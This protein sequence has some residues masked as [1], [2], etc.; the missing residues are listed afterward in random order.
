MEEFKA[1]PVFDKA[2][3]QA[4]GWIKD[5]MYE[6]NLEDSAKTYQ[7]LRVTLHTLRDRILPHEAVHLGAQLP[8]LLRGSYYDGWKM[9]KKPLK[10]KTKEELFAHIKESYN[11]PLPVDAEL[12]VRAVFKLLRHRVSTGE[13][14]DIEATLPE[15]LRELWPR[16][17]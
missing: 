17:V 8:M 15:K 12:L 7:M 5:L 4:H 16:E 9:S 10:L 2:V 6:L 11:V 14:E 3:Q 1:Y 13:I